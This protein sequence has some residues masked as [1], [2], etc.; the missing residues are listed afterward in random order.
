M[1]R[2]AL[3]RRTL[4]VLSVFKAL[5]EE[6]APLGINR[7]LPFPSLS[8]I[9]IHC[10]HFDS[11]DAMSFAQFVTALTAIVRR[12]RLSPCPI[13]ELHIGDSEIVEAAEVELLRKYNPGLTVV[14]D[15]E[16]STLSSMDT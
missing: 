1:D 9:S 14:W 13:S 10:N 3:P 2:G 15:G 11:D 12:R 8:I 4:P 6:S 7:T 16:N 5:G